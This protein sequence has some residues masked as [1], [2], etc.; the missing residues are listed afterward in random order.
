M[1]KSVPI[2]RTDKNKFSKMPYT[3]TKTKNKIISADRHFITTDKKIRAAANSGFLL[4]RVTSKL[5]VFCFL[6]PL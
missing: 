6:L 2:L 5:K 1:Q 4:L 3:K